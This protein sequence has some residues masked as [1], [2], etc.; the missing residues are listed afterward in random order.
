MTNYVK[1]SKSSFA[2][3]VLNGIAGLLPFLLILAFHIVF[4]IKN[5]EGV[6]FYFIAYGIS[7][8]NMIATFRVSVFDWDLYYTGEHLFL[9]NLLSKEKFIDTGSFIVKSRS[10]LTPYAFGYFRVIHN[11]K[12]YYIRLRATRSTF[13][14]FFEVPEEICAELESM[15]NSYLNNQRRNS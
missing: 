9:K 2:D 8:F 3:R 10:F 4:G 12:S 11:S 1:I 7:T 13:K 15:L 6:F 5:I 14:G